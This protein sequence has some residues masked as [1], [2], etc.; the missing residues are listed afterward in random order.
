MKSHIEQL[1]AQISND[2]GSARAA[3]HANSRPV[4]LRLLK[5]DVKNQLTSILC[6]CSLL[7]QSSAD[8]KPKEAGYIDQIQASTKAIL[9]LLNGLG[10][11]NSLTDPAVQNQPA[12]AVTD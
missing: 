11:G 9:L 1:A 12:P 2:P 10:T 5:H 6:F 8:L 3:S 4:D 7:R